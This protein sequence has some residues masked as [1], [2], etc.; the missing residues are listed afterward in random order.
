[1]CIC[2]NMI[3]TYKENISKN[4]VDAR[5]TIWLLDRT[6]ED[7]KKGM[8]TIVL[9]GIIIMIITQLPLSVGAIAT[10]TAALRIDSISAPSDIFV[11]FYD[12]GI[13]FDKV[14]Q[15][16]VNQTSLAHNNTPTQL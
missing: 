3:Y 5:S 14:A 10:S 8:I 2:A 7:K 13:P 4:Y 6:N 9:F 12:R 1:M 11:K 16:I 15:L